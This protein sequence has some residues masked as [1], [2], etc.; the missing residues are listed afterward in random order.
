VV[1]AI[2]GIFCFHTSSKALWEVEVN[3]VVIA[4]LGIF[5][6]HI[7]CELNGT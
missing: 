2:L 5:F 3:D 6:F 1:I 7:F 4:I